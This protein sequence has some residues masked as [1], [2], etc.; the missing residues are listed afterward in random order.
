MVRVRSFKKD[1][2]SFPTIELIQPDP[3][4]KFGFTFGL[5]KARLILANIRDIEQFVKDH[6]PEVK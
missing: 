5:T 6:T 4:L 3:K 1:G 2:V